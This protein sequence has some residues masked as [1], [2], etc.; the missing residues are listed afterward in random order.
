MAAM[1]TEAARRTR[2]TGVMWQVDHI[3]PL[4]G[5]NVCGLHIPENLQLLTAAENARK[6]NRFLAEAAD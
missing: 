3:V 4:K 5:R 2:E 6:G 1:Y